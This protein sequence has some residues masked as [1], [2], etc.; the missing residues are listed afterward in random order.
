MHTQ[1]KSSS[2]AKKLRRVEA[3]HKRPQSPVAE[4]KTVT[5]A[6][7]YLAPSGTE[8]PMD[9]FEPLPIQESSHLPVSVVAS[10]EALFNLSKNSPCEK[11]AGPVIAFPDEDDD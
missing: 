8:C 1:Y 11:K 3:Q 9:E 7:Q 5:T 6:G 10:M 2:R 4:P